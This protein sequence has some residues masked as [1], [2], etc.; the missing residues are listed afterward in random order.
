M[1]SPDLEFVDEWTF[2]LLSE[3]RTGVPDHMVDACF[4]VGSDLRWRRNGAY[5]DLD[6]LWWTLSLHES[7]AFQLGLDSSGPRP[8]VTSDTEGDR[9]L[10]ICLYTVALHRDLT[11][12]EATVEIADIVQAE[13][14]G[15]PPWVHWPS[16]DKRIL[17][18]KLVDG[19]AVWQDPRDGTLVAR[20]GELTA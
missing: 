18:P 16:K 14:T 9:Y 1:W 15:Y 7:G 4:A 10:G 19:E 8:R 17:F 11:L 2:P 5:I 6:R 3:S 12:A 13:L 20:I